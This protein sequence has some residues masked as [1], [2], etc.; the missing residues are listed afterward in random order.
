MP[1]VNLP[2]T[3]NASVSPGSGSYTGGSAD[4]TNLDDGSDSTLFLLEGDIDAQALFPIG[5]MPSDLAI[6]DSVTINFRM[7]EATKGDIADLDYVQIME[8][9]GVTALTSASS[10]VSSS[11]MTSFTFTPG[12]LYSTAKSDWDGAKILIK[13]KNGEA[14]TYWAELSVDIEYS[15]ASPAPPNGSGDAGDFFFVMEEED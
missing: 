5:D 13:N 7:R 4:Y 11:T 1:T 8:A 6:V 10:S 9:D 14:A 12:T 15:L 3:A 2:P